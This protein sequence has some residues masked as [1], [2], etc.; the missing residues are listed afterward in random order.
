MWWYTYQRKTEKIHVASEIHSSTP[1]FCSRELLLH[2]AV[3]P[4]SP[5]CLYISLWRLLRDKIPAIIHWIQSPLSNETGFLRTVQAV[6]WIN[7]QHLQLQEQKHGLN[8]YDGLGICSL[9]G[10]CFHLVSNVTE[11]KLLMLKT[12]GTYS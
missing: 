5:S 7:E 10:C 4:Y 1:K 8:D 11:I 3:P 6:F 2:N 12:T 9:A